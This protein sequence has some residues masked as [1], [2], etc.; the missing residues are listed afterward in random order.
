V[1][2]SCS[3]LALC[4]VLGSA[5]SLADSATIEAGIFDITPTLLL[6]TQYDDNITQQ[7]D[8]DKRHSVVSILA[9]SVEAVADNGAQR[10]TLGYAFTGGRYASSHVDDFADN[11]L[12]A[13]V[14]WT[15]NQRNT[16]EL[17]A[18]YFDG[19]EDRGT[20]D[21]SD[22][23]DSPDELKEQIVTATYTLGG[24]TSRARL[25]TEL[26]SLDSEYTN[27]RDLTESRDRK[28]LKL[29]STFYWRVGGKT[30]LLL[31]ATQTD[32]DYDRDPAALANAFDTLDSE[33]TTLMAGVTWEATAKTTG[34]FKIGQD[35]RDYTDTDR[36]NSDNTSW[37][38]SVDW[39]PL[40]YSVVSFSSAQEA[41]ENSGN[42]IDS[43][44]YG[45]SWT[46]N[47][48]QSFSSNAFYEIADETHDGELLG[49]EDELTDYGVRVDYAMRR[50]LNVGVSYTF[51]DRE[52]NVADRNYERNIT[53]L[54]LQM[55]L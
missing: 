42:Y 19:H 53:A 21:F 36:Q 7:V 13:G 33:L 26:Q 1:K 55:S 4:A 28:D 54:H 14:A 35:K 30:D 46:H 22:G 6:D 37:Y 49:R 15:L 43:E 34:T 16:L 29:G 32:I 2:T 24:E 18:E 10:Y 38:L 39:S 25:V 45:V 51:A 11:T 17:N 47:W 12:T 52:S 44:S 5:H 31:E 50:W 23:A 9:P 20:N 8:A 3:L 48:S 41:T 40:T 27:N